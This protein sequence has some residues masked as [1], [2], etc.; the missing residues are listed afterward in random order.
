MAISACFGLTLL[1][2]EGAATALPPLVYDNGI[3]ASQVS[4]GRVNDPDFAIPL[5]HAD[6]FSIATTSQ[7]ASVT[8]HGLYET[9]LP[10]FQGDDFSLSLFSTTSGVINP[11]PPSTRIASAIPHKAAQEKNA[12]CAGRPSNSGSP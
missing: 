4:A 1:R 3:L 11:A 12:F 5:E 2:L 8:W 6:N 9:N 7:I 10:L